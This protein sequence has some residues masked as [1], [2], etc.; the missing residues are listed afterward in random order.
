MEA[1]CRELEEAQ[2]RR[3][4]AEQLLQRTEAEKV[5]LQFRVDR[6][7]EYCKVLQGVVKTLQK[8]YEL[9][10]GDTGGPRRGSNLPSSPATSQTGHEG[11]I[12]ARQFS[13]F[14]AHLGKRKPVASHG[15][16]AV[17]TGIGKM[18]YHSA[19]MLSPISPMWEH[20]SRPLPTHPPS[21]LASRGRPDEKV[22]QL[23]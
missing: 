9:L 11:P 18:P 19:P 20:K 10:C 4:S 13:Q 22:H 15:Y 17:L 14:P 8:S 21:S 6:S 7:E 12:A 2:E 1:K 16:G 5:Q 23:R 3:K